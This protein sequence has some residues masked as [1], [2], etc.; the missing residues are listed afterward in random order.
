MKYERMAKPQL[1]NELMEMR[2]LSATVR[3]LKTESKQA[4]KEAEKLRELNKELL[5]EIAE[6]KK[7]KEG[8]QKRYDLERKHR[9]LLEKERSE[10][11]QFINTL[12]HELKTPLTAVVASG[13]LLLEELKEDPHSARVRLMENIIRGTE[14]LTGRLSE[15]LDMARMES[16]GFKLRTELLDI[17]PLLQ[18]VAS[19]VLPLI[20]EK[21]QSLTLDIPSSAPMVN[22][23]KQHLEQ[24]MLN[25]L[26]NATKFTGDG[27]KLKIKL[28]Q[29]GQKLV[30][31]VKDNGPGITEEE[32]A[33]IF[34]PYYRIEADRQRFPGLGLGLTVSKHLV[35]MHGGMMWVESKIGEG[36]TFAFSLP[37]A[38]QEQEKVTNP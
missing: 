11:L 4:E 30:V 3:G 38:E 25:L 37:L 6:Y 16:V 33:R 32:R 31:Q 23:D 9:V 12:A 29:E 20:N 1:S 28:R 14:R 2:Q 18:S 21:K 27:G 7:S 34:T 10:R 15:L 24:I 8:L 35:E 13:G 17:R 26:T 36:T 22:I 19:E 5:A